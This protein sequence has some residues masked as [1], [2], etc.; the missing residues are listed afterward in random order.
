MLY[1]LHLNLMWLR[2][3][4]YL[5]LM[6]YNPY[7]HFN[8][9]IFSFSASKCRDNQDDELGGQVSFSNILPGSSSHTWVVIS[10]EG[11]GRLMKLPT[12]SHITL[13]FEIWVLPGEEVNVV[14]FTYFC[15]S[16]W[17]N[18]KSLY[19]SKR[20]WAMAQEKIKDALSFIL[21]ANSLTFSSQLQNTLLYNWW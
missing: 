3:H 13:I 4:D 6:V 10:D 8:V 20:S 7:C 16:L 11:Q 9:F 17:V 15:T 12:E 1:S 2:K 21:K 5:W 18:L 19:S 14:V